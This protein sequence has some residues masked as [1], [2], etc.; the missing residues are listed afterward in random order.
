M[1]SN[2]MSVTTF[3][4]SAPLENGACPTEENIFK[5]EAPA[6]SAR[7]LALPAASRPAVEA[8]RWLFSFSSWAERGARWGSDQWNRPLRILL[9]WI[10]GKCF[11]FQGNV[12]ESSPHPCD[13]LGRTFFA[14]LS[15]CLSPEGRC[16]LP[17]LGLQGALR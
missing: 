7:P 1:S 5:I 15:P 10:L 16:A 13:E 6:S 11:D 3:A 17:G 14:F 9:S 8:W 2:T 4:L 12:S